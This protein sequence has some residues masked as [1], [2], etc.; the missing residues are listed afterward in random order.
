MPTEAEWEYACRAG[1]TTAY[2]WGDDPDEIDDYAWY[3]ENSDDTYHKVGQKKPNP[4]GLY[5]IHGNVAE[6]VLD[7]Y[8]P[9]AYAAMS[10]DKPNENPFLPAQG[11]F[12][13]VVRGGS[14]DDEAD[15]PQRARRFSETWWKEQDPQ[16]PQSIWYHT[17]AQFAGFRVVPAGRAERRAEGQV[18][19]RR[20]RR[21]LTT[22]RGRGTCGTR[23]LPH[24]IPERSTNPDGS[25]QMTKPQ[26]TPGATVPSRRDFLKQ[27]SA[28]VGTGWPPASSRAA[29][30]PVPMR[31]FASV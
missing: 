3:F 9:Q 17:D 27:S 5:D 30:T 31:R 25:H 11:P 19:G 22:H 2:S 14:W 20:V 16:I 26:S 18:P 24:R 28:V 10:Q 6:W 1:T 21:R 7:E 4:W 8:D 23:P 12:N 29:C 15:A 13:Q